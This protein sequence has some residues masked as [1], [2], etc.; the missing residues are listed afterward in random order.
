MTILL[1]IANFVCLGDYY[2]LELDND[3]TLTLRWFDY[4]ILFWYYLVDDEV[5]LDGLRLQ[6]TSSQP[7]KDPGWNDELGCPSV[8][9][10][11]A[12]IVHQVHHWF[13]CNLHSLEFYWLVNHGFEFFD[14]KKLFYVR[15]FNLPL[16]YCCTKF[17][18]WMSGTEF[19]F[20]KYDNEWFR[21]SERKLWVWYK[22]VHLHCELSSRIGVSWYCHT[23]RSRVYLVT[24]VCQKPD[25]DQYEQWP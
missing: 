12:A 22:I 21:N 20:C 17:W 3:I 9:N 14:P 19:W 7:P 16:L 2:I 15:S 10:Q 13:S 1:L 6:E 11:L 4:L 8:R 23:T 5:S 24:Q 25:T 18:T